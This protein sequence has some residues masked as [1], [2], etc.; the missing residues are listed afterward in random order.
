MASWASNSSLQAS[1]IPPYFLSSA[2]VAGSRHVGH[3]IGIVQSFMYPNSRSS[4]G[5]PRVF[6]SSSIFSVASAGTAKPPT[7]ELLPPQFHRGSDGQLSHHEPS[8]GPNIPI[9]HLT[10][11]LSSCVSLLVP[12][13]R[14]DASRRLPLS[15]IPLFLRAAQERI[16]GCLLHTDSGREDLQ[17]PHS[18]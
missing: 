4:G 2:R 14:S 9:T 6:L 10:K 7:L 11:F 1:H 13:S 15:M 8:L 17:H 5:S 18:I 16:R 12:Y 3:L